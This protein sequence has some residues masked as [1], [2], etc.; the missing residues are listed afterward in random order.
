MANLRIR[1]WFGQKQIM[2]AVLG[3]DEFFIPENTYRDYHDRGLVIG[4]LIQW[5]VEN[6]FQN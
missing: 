2:E 1:Q 4:E 6:N 3:F 5:A